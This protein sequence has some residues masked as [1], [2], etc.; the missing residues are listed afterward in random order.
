M[1][2]L[3]GE[4]AVTRQPLSEVNALDVAAGE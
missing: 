4:K 2:G 1:D 3:E